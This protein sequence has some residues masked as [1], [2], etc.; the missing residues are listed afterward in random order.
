MFASDPHLKWRTTCPPVYRQVCM[1]GGLVK[2]FSLSFPP[3]GN[4]CMRLPDLSL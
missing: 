4:V 1:Y 3:N 2:K